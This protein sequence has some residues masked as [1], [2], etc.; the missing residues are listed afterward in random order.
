ML[1]KVAPVCKPLP[2][3]LLDMLGEA[4]WRLYETMTSYDKHYN[5]VIMGAMASQITSITIV[6]SI[7]Y[8]DADQTK[9]QSSASLAFVRG[10]HRLPVDS[11][12]KWP[13]TRKMFP[14]DDVIMQSVI[15]INFHDM[16]L[17]NQYIFVPTSIY[18][19]LFTA[20]RTT[21]IMV[22]IHVHQQAVLDIAITVWASCTMV[23]DIYS[24]ISD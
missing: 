19:M 22:P 9:H 14:F 1:V 17:I 23:V 16:Q 8:S 2:G 21:I 11:P 12:H 18:Q 15:L 7:V 4:S 10:I 5:D 13:V 3:P 6:Y 24:V 20:W